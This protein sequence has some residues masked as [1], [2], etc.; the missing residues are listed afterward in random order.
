MRPP[1]AAVLSVAELDL[2]CA[3]LDLEPPDGLGGHG[4]GPAAG[5]GAGLAVRGL[6]DGSTSPV[7]PA[8]RRLVRAPLVLELRHGHRDPVTA[9]AALGPDR[10]T[11]AVRHRC[12]VDLREVPAERATAAVLDLLGPLRPARARPVR[13]PVRVLD[14]ALAAAG[15]DP[16][17]LVVE[18]MHRG[19]PGCAARTLVAANHDVDA[20]ARIG[21]TVRTP[22]GPRPGPHRLTVQHTAVGHHVQQPCP[23]PEQTWE[24]APATRR[25]LARG[26]D[27][28]VRAAA[29]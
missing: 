21:A 15:D 9:I 17:R 18:L 2:L 14:D 29:D 4:D 28:L 26:V 12:R 25:R 22:A 20:R 10:A 7:A 23:G 27:D 3:V 11:I 8:L 6:L 19:M 16:H 13:V 1:V 24:T 5:V